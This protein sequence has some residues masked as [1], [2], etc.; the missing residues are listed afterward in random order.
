MSGRVVSK[1]ERQ[2]RV[3]HAGSLPD[4]RRTESLGSSANL[5]TRSLAGNAA[6]TQQV[7][8][9]ETL[10]DGALDENALA[11]HID[12]DAV[13]LIPGRSGSAPEYKAL[14]ET[15]EGPER[16]FYQSRVF[17]DW[18]FKGWS[19]IRA[20]ADPLGALEYLS[21]WL[22]RS[23]AERNA[24][25]ADLVQEGRASAPP[26]QD[27]S[28]EPKSL[29]QTLDPR[30][31]TDATLHQEVGRIRD[32]LAAGSNEGPIADR[33]RGALERL[34]QEAT[35]RLSLTT[36]ALT[37]NY[38]GL[39]RRWV[40]GRMAQG[41]R[42]WFN[43]WL[44][45]GREISWREAAP[46]LQGFMD[47]AGEGGAYY[48]DQLPVF[49][50]PNLGF[51]VQSTQYGLEG[52]R[53]TLTL[54][55]W[56]LLPRDSREAELAIRFKKASL[57]ASLGDVM[58]GFNSLALGPVLAMR[59]GG[60]SGAP[61]R[62]T[63]PAAKTPKVS[64]LRSLTAAVLLSLHRGAPGRV[65]GGSISGASASRVAGS[66]GFANARPVG[67]IVQT[68]PVAQTV[69][70]PE[71]KSVAPAA[72]AASP[73]PAGPAT[74]QAPS[75][76]LPNEPASPFIAPL[77]PAERQTAE[78]L[79]GRSLGLAQSGPAQVVRW[80]S[81]S[82]KSAATVV[83]A[84]PTGEA[85]VMD[86]QARAEGGELV[87]VRTVKGEGG[88]RVVR[89]EVNRPNFAKRERDKDLAR[90][91]K[92]VGMGNWRDN[93]GHIV[94]FAEGGADEPFNFESQPGSWNK[95]KK[96]R[97]N[98]RT[99]ERLLERF[100]KSNEGDI[101]KIEVTRKL[102]SLNRLL[103]ERFV[104]RN[105]KGDVTFDKEVT[106]RGKLTHYDELEE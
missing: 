41:G 18:Y 96:G 48:E 76:I 40:E 81:S 74:S 38:S 16:E 68:T 64:R 101:G 102:N 70:A 59:R 30:T 52:G 94:P 43:R 6:L 66:E 73:S 27:L 63:K 83:K 87:T 26:P 77:T 10:D 20:Y 61:L 25:L 105:L 44:E 67:P 71:L 28:A 31:L 95:S 104:V 75:R 23:T 97:V 85:E 9:H 62:I 15:L 47:A 92:A 84:S 46:V 39:P 37:G 98:R 17:G 7:G 13:W 69:A 86:F 42:E 35:D 32:W 34:R 65:S 51:Y 53:R 19:A 78:R 91:M 89:V 12:G 57:F 24:F 99:L 93:E 88:G 3:E 100:V 54:E 72:P 58:P 29:Q 50:D 79:L 11:A 90:A 33:L 8:E 5:A 80:Q 21:L 55:R 82:P 49:F 36:G 14:L 1:S 22:A 45:G 56:F 60:S 103:S 4:H 2:G 106:T